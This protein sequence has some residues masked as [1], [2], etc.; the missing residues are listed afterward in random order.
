MKITSYLLGVL[1]RVRVGK[2]REEGRASELGGMEGTDGEREGR[3]SEVRVEGRGGSKD[4]DW[5]CW[6]SSDV[7]SRGRDGRRHFGDTGR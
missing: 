4:G 3:S 7:D 2:R 6:G 5:G 1:R